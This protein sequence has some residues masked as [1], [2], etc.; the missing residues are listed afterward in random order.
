MTYPKVCKFDV[1][2]AAT[3]KQILWFQISMHD[4]LIMDHF[5]GKTYL[6]EESPNLVF[7][8]FKQA[9]HIPNV[10]AVGSWR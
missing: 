7:T 8:K 1:V 6:D 2:I 3:H 10:S 9:V 5:K 4:S